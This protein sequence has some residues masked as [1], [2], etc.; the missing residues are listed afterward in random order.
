MSKVKAQNE[1]M[2]RNYF[3]HL[4]DRE[5]YSVKTVEVVENAIWK[6]E[7]FTK[8]VDYKQFDEKNVRGF[9]KWLVTNVNAKSK[10][11]LGLK[12]QYDILR[13]LK[14]FFTWLSGQPG[15]KSRILIYNVD[16]LRLDKKQ[17]REAKTAKRADYPPLEY[18]KSLCASIDVKNEIDRRDRAL[19]AIA[20]LS[21]MRE[22]SLSTL[23]MGCFDP[24]TLKIVQGSEYDVKTKFSKRI[25]GKLFKFDDELLSYVLDWYNY[26]KKE[27][28]FSD[29]DP[30]FPKAKQKMN[31]NNEIGAVWDEVDNKCWENPL[32]VRKVFEER[33]NRAGLKFY[34]P[35]KFRHTAIYEI[36]SRVNTDK[37]RRAISQSLGHE[38][39]GTTY[40]YG[41]LDDVTVLEVL[42]N[43][44]FDNNAESK[45]LSTAS[46]DE[47]LS[48]LSRR[49]K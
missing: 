20:V 28:L 8:E 38:N 13:H 24:E 49:I 42:D 19:I 48:E 6:Y 5:G 14:K 29:I 40:S 33:A 23:K 7:E 3:K 39:I 41:K 31:I 46:K 35:H 44:N 22:E 45:S 26:L 4:R 12:S 37:E 25:V 27:K 36:S 47:L 16:C 18:V 21:G 15:Y 43:I 10:K 2:K 34:S 17:S 32:S 11:K 30:L 1:K 9:K